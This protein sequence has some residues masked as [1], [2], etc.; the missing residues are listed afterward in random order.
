M[1]FSGILL[2]P[3]QRC[4]ALQC[5]QTGASALSLIQGFKDKRVLWF[6]L[7]LFIHREQKGFAKQNLANN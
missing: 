4:A 3:E 7:F 2:L 1:L 6:P 5:S